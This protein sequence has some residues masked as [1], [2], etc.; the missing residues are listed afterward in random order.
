MKWLFQEPRRDPE[1]GDALRKLE[2]VSGQDDA[3]LR[4]RILAAA[5]PQLNAMRSPSR[6]WWEWVTRWMPV[7]IPLGIAASLAAGLILPAAE[8][9]SLL[10]DYTTEALGD[11]TL[12][13][14][15]YSEESDAGQLTAHVVAPES[16]DWLFEQAVA[17]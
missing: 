3:D 14:A 13:A 15:A 11:S 7:A 10:T 2:R 1:L 12:L 9:V 6:Q 4:Q 5:T 16:G 8:E 17:R